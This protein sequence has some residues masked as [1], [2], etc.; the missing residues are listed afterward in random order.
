MA[1]P[2]LAA[3]MSPAVDVAGRRE[4]WWKGAGASVFWGDAACAPAARVG[5]ACCAGTEAVVHCHAPDNGGTR[6]GFSV[7]SV[8]CAPTVPQEEEGGQG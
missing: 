5:P 1:M 8:M 6:R 7:G 3:V 2:T 4:S